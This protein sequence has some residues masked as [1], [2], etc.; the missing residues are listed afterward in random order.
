MSRLYPE[1]LVLGSV[2]G[3][4]TGA[5]LAGSN[6]TQQRLMLGESGIF[7]DVSELQEGQQDR[8]VGAVAKS[9]PWVLQACWAPPMIAQGCNEV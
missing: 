2:P 5:P 1:S 4:D 3:C 7:R 6:V 8:Q 9:D